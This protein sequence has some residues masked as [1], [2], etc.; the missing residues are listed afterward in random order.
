MLRQISIVSDSV[1][2]Q[3]LCLCIVKTLHGLNLHKF[4]IL[5]DGIVYNIKCMCKEAEV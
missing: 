3:Q 1:S 5:N 2:Y 4:L